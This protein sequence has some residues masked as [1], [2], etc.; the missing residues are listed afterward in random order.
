MGRERLA[1]TRLPQLAAPCSR[2]TASSPSVLD[3]FVDAAEEVDVQTKIQLGDMLERVNRSCYAAFRVTCSA[4]KEPSLVDARHGLGAR[5]DRV[6]VALDQKGRMTVVSIQLHQD[7]GPI[8]EY[9]VEGRFQ[10]NEPQRSAMYSAT[11]SSPPSGPPSAGLTLLIATSSARVFAGPAPSASR[12]GDTPSHARLVLA[13]R[14]HATSK[15]SARRGGRRRADT[16]LGSSF[17]SM[18]NLSYVES[19]AKKGM[20]LGEPARATLRAARV[21]TKT[22]AAQIAEQVRAAIAAG[23][24]H[25]GERLPPEH[26]LASQFGVSRPVVREAIKLLAASQLVESTRGAGGGTFIALPKPDAVAEQIGEALAFWFQHGNI[27]LAEVNEARAS[28]ER[29]CV[30]LAAERRTDA[31]LE[32]MKSCIDRARGVA[33]DEVFLE[34]RSRLPCRGEHGVEEPRPRTGDDSDSPRPSAD[35]SLL[36]AAIERSAVIAQ[37]SAIYEAIADRAP[38][39][40][41]AAFVEHVAQL[42]GRR[43]TRADQPHTRRNPRLPGT[44]RGSSND[45]VAAH[46]RGAFRRRHASV[47]ADCLPAHFLEHMTWQEVATRIEDGVDC[48]FIPVGSTEQHGPHMPLDTDCAIARSLCERASHLAHSEGMSVLVAPTAQRFA[49]VVSHAVPW[50][51]FRLS[52]ANVLPSLP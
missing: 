27:S 24:V 30:R 8:W 37:H 39:R 47:M 31:D 42:C 10:P 29:T 26:E 11:R 17:A 22:A 20:T 43:R 40:A 38:D 9:V 50:T 14:R 3:L 46:L 18:Y 28:I 2:G 19:Q 15:T 21:S 23:D 5:R 44:K 13:A 36:M 4:T 32:A 1:P 51:P 41:E 52:T 35:E 33:S 49:L 16:V 25:P 7:V 45:R 48:V 12:P 6:G 34:P